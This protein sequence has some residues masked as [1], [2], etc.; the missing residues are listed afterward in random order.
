ME[1]GERIKQRREELGMTQDEL[2]QKAG[3]AS[4]SSINKIEKS[5]DLPSTRIE[6]MAHALECSPSYLMG[7]TG[8]VQT[9]SDPGGWVAHDPRSSPMLDDYIRKKKYKE[10]SEAVERNLL[11]ELLRERRSV[12]LSDD[13]YILVRGFRAAGFERRED[14]LELARKAIGGIR[15][16]EQ[17]ETE[18]QAKDDEEIVVDAQYEIDQEQFDAIALQFAL[19]NRLATPMKFKK[20]VKLSPELKEALLKAYRAGR[21]SSDAQDDSVDEDAL[22]EAYNKALESFVTV[23]IKKKGEA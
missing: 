14:M 12:E 20:E 11:A 19:N 21:I 3:Y 18:K 6:Q 16:D 22:N 8:Q 2:A 4:R 5:R 13:E 9:Q 1:I 7:W 17:P 15:I 23:G 10:H